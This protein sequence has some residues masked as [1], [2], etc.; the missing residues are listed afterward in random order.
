MFS[1][2]LGLADSSSKVC[3]QQKMSL[4]DSSISLG[5]ERI[6]E[7]S[8]AISNACILHTD[9]VVSEKLILT[10]GKAGS[11]EKISLDEF[12]GCPQDEAEAN[13][14]GK[15][16]EL[17]YTA[18]EHRP[19]E[20]VS[21]EEFQDFH[22]SKRKRIN[23]WKRFV[24]IRK[25]GEG[26]VRSK[27]NAGTNKTQRIKVK[28]NKKRCLEF[29]GLYLGQEVRAH[30]GLVW[31]M[32]FSPCGQYLASGGEDGA[33][34]IWCVT[35]LDKSSICFTPQDNTSKSKV[36]CDN[37]SPRKKHLS[38][39]FIFLRNS[40]F[41]IEESPLQQFFGHSN[42]VLDL[43]QLTFASGM[44]SHVAS[45]IKG[46]LPLTYKGTAQALLPIIG[47]WKHKEWHCYSS[48]GCNEEER[49]ALVN[50]KESFKDPSSRLSSWEGSDC[51]QWKGVA[52]NNVTG[53]VVKLD[54]RN[55]CYPLR[56]QG[57]FQPNY[58]L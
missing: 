53:H 15:E 21:Q 9:E 26:N 22:I 45:S 43:V 47:W 11:K 49:Q 14:Q 5:L 1:A 31:T 16:H 41:Q 23:W 7:C 29:S 57:Y 13:I 34:Q 52:C 55:P 39:P 50:I 30:N 3:S 28:H 4:D 24:N 2:G 6:R 44:E 32:K 8:G 46:S 36:E 48:L 56:D 37:S 19:R 42:D 35:S 12:K 18:Q 54:L 58:S 33:V 17:S 10:G 25:S 27:L 20:G 51:C 38:Q 40:V